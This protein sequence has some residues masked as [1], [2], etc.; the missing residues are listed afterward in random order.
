VE[1]RGDALL[2]SVYDLGRLIR[3]AI[4]AAAYK[5]MP[6]RCPFGSVG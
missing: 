5:A 6:P 1:R 3:I 2:V 4:T